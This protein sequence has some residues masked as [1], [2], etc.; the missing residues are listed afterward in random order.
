MVCSILGILVGSSLSWSTGT[1]TLEISPASLAINIFFSGSQVNLF[2]SILSDR[3]IIIEI[4][5]PEGKGEFNLKAKVGPFWMNRKKVEIQQTPFFYV[6][7][8]PQN[9]SFDRDLAIPGIGMA[10]LKKNFSIRP[11]ELPAD[12]VFDLFVQLKRSE[13]LYVGPLNSIRYSEA[14]K[15][16][17]RFSANFHLPSSTAKGE[18]RVRASVIHKGAVEDNLVRNIRVRETGIVQGIHELAHR[19]SLF[20]GILAVMIA[21]VVGMIMGVV[22][23]GGKSH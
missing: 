23:K 9:G 6:L 11:D 5:G 1:A 2:G 15:G 18:Y 8:L 22:F 12:K 21:L 13:K 4:I 20:Y 16:K 17:K 7:L 3:D 14:E 19:H 10:N